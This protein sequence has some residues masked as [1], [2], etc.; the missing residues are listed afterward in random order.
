[1]SRD[2]GAARRPFYQPIVYYAC[3]WG[4]FVVMRLLY[5]L[6]RFHLERIPRHGACVLVANHQSY[7]DPPIIGVS[8]PRQFHP[9]ARIGL[10]QG[11]FFGW[12]IRTL[13]SIP[14]DKDR[15]D[16]TAIRIALERL[17][18]GGV[19]CLFP[20]GARSEDGR[21]HEFRRGVLLLLRRANCPI[22]PMAIDGAYDIWP[23]G[24]NRPRWRGRLGL[25]VGEPIA[26]DVLFEQY[27][28]DPI[29]EI[30]Q[31]V[32]GLHAELRRTMGREPVE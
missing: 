25:I 1:M 13:N 21:I 2:E 22:V 30:E 11:R 28:A 8:V 15:V 32:R 9:M 19:I 14:I 27:K 18:H 7:L 31:R 3:K 5:R 6:R 12:L 29:G 23:R 20:E 24:R 4:A 26:S 17:E 16:T 10:F